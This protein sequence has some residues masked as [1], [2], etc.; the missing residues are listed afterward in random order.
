MEKNRFMSVRD[1]TMVKEIKQSSPQLRRVRG[2][3]RNNLP[4]VW[5][6]LLKQESTCINMCCSAMLA[7]AR[8]LAW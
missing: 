3:V 8:K 1:P 2:K 7:A 4:R 6:R 5:K